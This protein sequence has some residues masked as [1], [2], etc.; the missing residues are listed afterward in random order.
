MKTH[1]LKVVPEF[2][3]AIDRGDKTFESR[4]DDRGFEVG[5]S[6]HLREWTADGGYT[7]R[8]ITEGVAYILRGEQWG[9]MPGFACMAFERECP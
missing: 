1:E 3:D 4:F 2:F 7:G 5:D 8:A 6:L 9:V